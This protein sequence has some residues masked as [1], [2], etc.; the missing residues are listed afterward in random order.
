[1][2]TGSWRQHEGLVD[3]SVDAVTAEVADL[4]TA[5]GDLEALVAVLS[6]RHE[7]EPTVDRAAAGDVAE[8]IEASR[9]ITAANRIAD[10]TVAESQ[11]E[12][13]ELLVAAQVKGFEVIGVARGLA[14]AELVAER[15]RVAAATESWNTHRSEIGRHLASLAV[16]LDHF[17]TELAAAG[18]AIEAALDGLLDGGAGDADP[19]AVVAAG[20]GPADSVGISL[21]GSLA[22]MDGPPEGAVPFIVALPDRRATG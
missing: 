21:V 1:M 9:I 8:A 10:V 17:R 13:D 22:D 7:S 19:T 11:A 15:N 2:R 4:R 20:A 18:A 12:A 3:V 16:S 6:Q 5:I 14:E